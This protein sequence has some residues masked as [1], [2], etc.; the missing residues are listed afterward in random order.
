LVLK[1]NTNELLL[2]QVAENQK[3]I[4]RREGFPKDHRMCVCRASDLNTGLSASKFIT[5]NLHIE[6]SALTVP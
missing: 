3:E 2:H 6:E 5:L 4:Q 1:V